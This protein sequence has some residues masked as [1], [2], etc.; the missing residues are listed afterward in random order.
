[1]TGGMIYN[2][3][4]FVTFLLELRRQAIDGVGG[5]YGFWGKDL[6]SVSIM[7]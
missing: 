5:E 1:M 3:R 7:I 4:Y 6:I 2:V